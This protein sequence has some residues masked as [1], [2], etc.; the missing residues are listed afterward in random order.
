M[1]H[2]SFPCFILF[3]KV[4]SKNVWNP[5]GRPLRRFRTLNLFN[6]MRIS[7]AFRDSFTFSTFP[8]ILGESSKAR[9]GHSTT[10]LWHLKASYFM[11]SLEYSLRCWL[12]LQT[13]QG[14]LSVGAFWTSSSTT[15]SPDKKSRQ[16]SGW[17]SS[18]LRDIQNNSDFW[19]NCKRANKSHQRPTRAISRLF[20]WSILSAKSN[21]TSPWRAE[22]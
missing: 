2:A 16:K 21:W 19:S 4:D 8:K 20:I 12:T 22:G 17:C 14:M 6:L 13:R 18:F 5:Q 10:T 11:A 3:L 1:D 9:P 15:E 7:D